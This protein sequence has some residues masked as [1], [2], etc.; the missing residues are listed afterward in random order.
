[1]LDQLTVFGAPAEARQRIALWPAAGA[2]VTC[3]FLRPNLGSEELAFTLE[4]F[5]PMLESRTAASV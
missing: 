3:V 5:Q 1:L 2:D 4:A